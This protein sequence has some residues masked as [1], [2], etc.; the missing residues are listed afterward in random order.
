MGRKKKLSV[1]DKL[2][3]CNEVA[4]WS[5]ATSVNT[6][7]AAHKRSGQLYYIWAK[8]L[9]DQGYTVP[10]ATEHAH[11]VAD[12]ALPEK[13][14]A[15]PSKKV[16]KPRKAVKQATSGSFRSVMIPM[17]VRQG[18][19]VCF[20]PNNGGKQVAFWPKGADKPHLFPYDRVKALIERHEGN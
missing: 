2:E 7:M 9:R 12:P 1:L 10:A 16:S 15:K 4:R 19:S 5:H 17:R 14:R 3:I 8:Q 20:D 13:Y 11:K 6:I 18:L